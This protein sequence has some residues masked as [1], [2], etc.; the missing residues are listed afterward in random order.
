MGD[1]KEKEELEGKVV[2][3]PGREA[4]VDSSGNMCPISLALIIIILYFFSTTSL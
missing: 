1:V 2:V 3:G 4:I